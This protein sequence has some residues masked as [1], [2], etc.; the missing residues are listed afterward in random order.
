MGGLE[1]LQIYSRDAVDGMNPAFLQIDS[2]THSSHQKHAVSQT[3]QSPQFAGSRR[4]RP[5]PKLD[6]LLGR[7]RTEG[8]STRNPHPA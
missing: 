6:S 3:I 7:L 1:A 5:I 2:L 8:H 4:P